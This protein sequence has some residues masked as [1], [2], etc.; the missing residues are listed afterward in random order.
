MKIKMMDH[1]GNLGW[2]LIASKT[3]RIAFDHSLN[4]IRNTV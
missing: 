4:E 2:I 1:L 3:E